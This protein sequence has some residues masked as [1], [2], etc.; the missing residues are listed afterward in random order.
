MSK[1]K[2]IYG[3]AWIHGN[4]LVQEQLLV[5]SGSSVVSE[6]IVV[7]I[8]DIWD[9]LTKESESCEFG[10]KTNGKK[11]FYWEVQMTDLEDDSIVHKVKI[12][13]PAPKEGLFSEPY[14]P[15]KATGSYAKY[16]INH[17]KTAQENNEASF[18]IQKKS[19]TFPGSN[20][21]NFSTGELKKTEDIIIENNDLGD[22]SNLLGLF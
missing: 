17:Y 11:Y 2:T 22:I 16:W 7:L 13:C 21:F 15:E 12:E 3:Q 6:N 10:Y 9:N 20:Y 14:D 8:D 19:V 5:V 18:A 1:S 4:S